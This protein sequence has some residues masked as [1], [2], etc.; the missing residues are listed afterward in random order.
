ML[1]DPIIVRSPHRFLTVTKG[2]A[3]QHLQGV[4]HTELVYALKVK[5]EAILRLP[6]MTNTTSASFL[7]ES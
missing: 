7:L 3:G 2:D 1:L 5:W 6:Y 4:S